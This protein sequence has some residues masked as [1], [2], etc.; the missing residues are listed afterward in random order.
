MLHDIIMNRLKKEITK[1]APEN[2]QDDMQHFVIVCKVKK[3]KKKKKDG[4]KL[5]IESTYITNSEGKKHRIKIGSL[6]MV[7]DKK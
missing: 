6:G 1:Q 2:F 5:K 7:P 4:M 3:S